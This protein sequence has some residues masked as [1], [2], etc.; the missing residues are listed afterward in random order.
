MFY[1]TQILGRK[2][3]LGIIW[4]ASHMD[5]KIT[6]QLVDSTSIPGTVDTVLNG[7][8]GPLAL[9]L[10][11]QLLLGIVRIYARK[12]RGRRQQLFKTAHAKFGKGC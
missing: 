3:L 12:V 11:G 4:M 8:A 6:K 5:K 10:S 7:D 1:S 2:G 9:R